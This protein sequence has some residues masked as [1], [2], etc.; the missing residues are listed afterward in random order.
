MSVNHCEKCWKLMKAFVIWMINRSEARIQEILSLW[1]IDTLNNSHPIT[2]LMFLICVTI[3]KKENVEIYRIHIWVALQII[4]YNKQDKLRD[5]QSKKN[6]NDFSEHLYK[7]FRMWLELFKP[8]VSSV[9][10]P[11]KR[12]K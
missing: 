7:E 11:E 6:K 12:K 1:I 3:I 9:S 10:K 8:I 4:E 5:W 2:E